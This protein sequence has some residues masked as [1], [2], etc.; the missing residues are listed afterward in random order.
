VVQ[1]AEAPGAPG[2]VDC[3]LA[4]GARQHAATPATVIA[5]HAREQRSF[6]PL[7]LLNR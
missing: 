6:I 4:G 5:R 7:L 2:A 3:A 1:L